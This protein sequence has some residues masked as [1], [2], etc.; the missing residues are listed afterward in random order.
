MRVDSGTTDVPTATTR[1]QISNTKDR[2]KS[3]SVQGHPGN[4]GN[5]FFGVSDVALANG[6]VLEPGATK[7]LDFGDGSVF[8]DAFYV[9]AA[10]SGDDANWWV[11]L[12]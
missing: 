7:T 5:I 2:V 12:A 10:T 9:D 8:F 1:V 11:I 3:I 4:T 6:W